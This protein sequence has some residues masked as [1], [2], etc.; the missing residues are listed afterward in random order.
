[1]KITI[2]KEK[3]SGCGNCVSVCP[4]EIFAMEDGKSVAKRPEDCLGCRACETACPKGAIK[5][6]D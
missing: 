2:D 1:M 6:E 3:C 5:V 4:Q